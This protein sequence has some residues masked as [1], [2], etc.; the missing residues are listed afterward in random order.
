[1]YRTK[2]ERMAEVRPILEKL[3]QMRLKV[4]EHAPLQA[5]LALAQ[6]Y[7]RDGDRV[8]IYIPF[9]DLNCTIDGLLTPKVDERCFVKLTASK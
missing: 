6:Q 5:L 4:K 8:L 3:A 9:P 7:I 1:M 2:I